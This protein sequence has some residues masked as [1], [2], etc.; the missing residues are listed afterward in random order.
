MLVLG[1]ETSTPAS[2]V[3]VATEHGL[4]AGAAVGPG[5]PHLGRAHGAFLAPAIQFCLNAARLDIGQVS[6]VAVGLGPGLFTG[7]RVGIATAQALA[8]ARG[9]PMVGL[10][11]LDLLAFPH[12]Y[13]RR[14]ICSVLDARRGELSYA[15]YKSAPGGLQRVSEYRLGPPEKLAGEIEAAADQV[16]CVGDGAIAHR[17]LLESA[18]ADVGSASSAH[19]TAAALVELAL[20]RFIREETQRPGDLRPLYLRKADARI[21]WQHRGALR[22]GKAAAAGKA[23]G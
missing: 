20:P 14:S 9:L 8:H 18:G 19:P 7:M 4:V 2:G 5:L 23:A 12:R 11:S 6:G 1:I 10:A 16:L 3:C 13:V 15:F 17:A 22:G 21:S